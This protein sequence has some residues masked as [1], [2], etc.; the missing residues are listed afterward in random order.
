MRVDNRLGKAGP[1]TAGFVFV[2][3]CKKRFTRHDIDV[4]SDLLVVEVGTRPW[5]FG[6]TLLSDVK[7]LWC[8]GCDDTVGPYN[9]KMLKAIKELAVK[10]GQ[11]VC[12]QEFI[13]GPEVYCLLLADKQIHSLGVAEVYASRGPKKDGED[14]L[15]FK[16]E[17]KD[18]CLAG[19]MLYRPP[20][21]ADGVIEDVVKHSKHVNHVLEMSGLTR[22]DFRIK[23]DGT[24]A[25]IDIADNPGTSP[26]STLSYILQQSDFPMVDIDLLILGVGLR[27][28][29]CLNQGGQN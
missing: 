18:H 19:G 21:V 5:A 8:Q 4:D 9:D 16:L 2:R 26:A 24:P 11:L 22:I 7:L 6:A 12:V 15:E 17:F 25:V 23:N 13:E 3:R 20:T 28:V 27:D 29:R 1:A 10:I 14:Y